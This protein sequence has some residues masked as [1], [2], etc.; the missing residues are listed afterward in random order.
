MNVLLLSNFRTDG[1]SI[2]FVALLPEPEPEAADSAVLHHTKT[3]STHFKPLCA[4]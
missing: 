3:W 2:A 1:R 4:T